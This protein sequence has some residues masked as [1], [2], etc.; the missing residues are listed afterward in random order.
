M[1]DLLHLLSLSLKMDIFW[2]LLIIIANLLGIS[3]RNKEGEVY[4]V[5]RIYGETIYL[6]GKAFQSG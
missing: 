5:L 6:Q 2:F 3:Q 1:F 4:T